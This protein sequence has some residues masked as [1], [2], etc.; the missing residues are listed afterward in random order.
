METI[1]AA[2]QVSV[3]YGFNEVLEDVSFII[4]EGDY[5]GIIGPNGGG[6]TTLIK[7]IIGLI[8]PSSGKLQVFGNASIDRSH[9]SM[10][11]Y[12]PQRVATPYSFFPATVEEI[13]RGGRASH[14]GFFGREYRHDTEA[15]SEAL[16]EV[17]IVHLR[18]RLIY[19]LSGGERQRVFIARALARRPRLLIFDEPTVGV[20]VKVQQQF[21]QLL[22][23]LNKKGITVLLVSHDVDVVAGQVSMVLCLNKK[24]VC[25]VKAEEF[26]QENY[27]EKLYGKNMKYI[28]HH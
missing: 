9:R 12:V 19:E 28:F 15:V 17:E 21:Y 18:K 6:K 22:T 26:T 2:Q 23:N 4:R 7:L 1:I 20:D 16:Q 8:E 3:R 5:V 10:I 14:V 11:G 24:L 25:H 27:L 13:V